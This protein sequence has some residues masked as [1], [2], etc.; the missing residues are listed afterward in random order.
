MKLK[1]KEIQELKKKLNDLIISTK[2]INLK[3]KFFNNNA[4]DEI[5]IKAKG[6][7]K[8]YEVLSTL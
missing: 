5:S 3:F 4:K 1:D 7:S 2:V 8:I 6:E